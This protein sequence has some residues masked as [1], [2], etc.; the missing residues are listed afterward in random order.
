ML[1]FVKWP[2]VLPVHKG[3]VLGR[4]V[5]LPPQPT[6]PSPDI[7]LSLLTQFLVGLGAR[8]LGLAG[9]GVPAVVTLGNLPHMDVHG[10]SLGFV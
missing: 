1:N 5:F 9:G 7:P 6:H 8:A 4:G 10:H 3:G 2:L